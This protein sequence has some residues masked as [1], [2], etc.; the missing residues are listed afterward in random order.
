MTYNLMK[1]DQR[2]QR[3]LLRLPARPQD[4]AQRQ[5]GDAEAAG[6]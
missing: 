1:Y 2:A 6:G 4:H 3:H 5:A